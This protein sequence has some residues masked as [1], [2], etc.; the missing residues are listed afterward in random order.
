MN[1]GLG[2]KELVIEATG[3]FRPPPAV[4]DAHDKPE[5]ITAGARTVL[6]LASDESSIITGASLATDNGFA[7]GMALTTR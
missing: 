4:I 5:L 3:G 2:S 6:F 1:A 7:A